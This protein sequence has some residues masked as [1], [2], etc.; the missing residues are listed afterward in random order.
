LTHPEEMG[1]LFKVL[2]L[3]PENG[4]PPPGCTQ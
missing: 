4:T 2:A 3:Y 1:N